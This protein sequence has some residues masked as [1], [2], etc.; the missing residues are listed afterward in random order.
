MVMVV[1]ELVMA[2]YELIV[3]IFVNFL[4]IVV[5]FPI[6]SSG[7]CSIAMYPVILQTWYCCSDDKALFALWSFHLVHLF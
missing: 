1:V 6:Y 4:I 5:T 2:L 3:D 7:F